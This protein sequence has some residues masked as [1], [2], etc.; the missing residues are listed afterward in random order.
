MHPSLRA[1]ALA[2]L[3]AL[4]PTAAAQDSTAVT[5]AEAVAL[6]I[7]E[8]PD[9]RRSEAGDRGRSAAV[10]AARANRLP[11]LFLSVSPQQRYGLGFDQTTGEV[12]SQTVETVNVGVRA[13]VELY[14]GG[15]TSA[16]VRE[17]R[18]R[19]DA[20]E[21]G[22]GRTEQA[23]A[24]DVAQRFLTLLLDRELRAIEAEALA[25]AVAQRERVAELVA[26]GARPRGDLLAQEAVVAERRT[27]LVVAEGAVQS[28][29]VGLIQ[30][31]GLDPLG[32]YR[33]V[34]PDVD[35][36][37]ASGLLDAPTAPLAELLD[38]A[39]AARADR[40][41]QE[42]AIEAAEAGVAS[43]RAQ[44]R[45][46]LS[47]TATAGTGYSSLQQRTVGV[48]PVLPVTLDDGS[49]VLVGGVPLTFPGNPAFETTPVFTQAS[50]NRSGS[51][52]LQLSVPL[53]DRYQTRRSVVE[54]E[55]RAQEA[56]IQL[57]ALDRQVA[58][59][60]QQSFVEAGTA[61]ARLTAA[62][63]QVEAAT[64]ALRVERDRY[65]LGAGT[66]YDV[67]EAQAAVARA[68][69]VRAQAAYGLLFRQA[70]VRLAVGDIDPAEIA[71]LVGQ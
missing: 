10:R 37:Q 54:A 67:A 27:A 61:R 15:R 55:I 41:A 66:L 30:T 3:A 53:F 64:A 45:P 42:L 43:A 29:R 69:S 9:V 18:L 14:D 48:T 25:S 6:A 34:G 57:D 58:A 2:V 19:T 39:R 49:P 71:A 59:E 38:A 21:A 47:L 4:A 36:L 40:R 22:L 32:A 28:D 33:F 11:D 51:I 26:A 16:L 62:V 24:L 5:L 20:A 46:S 1:L 44:G 31:I 56:R 17:A 50:D 8:S 12:V 70:L 23:V 52:G 60:V 7:E 65:R 35:R 63:A 13:S 68:Q